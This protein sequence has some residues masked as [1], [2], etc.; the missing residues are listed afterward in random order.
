MLGRLATD[1]R[2]AGIATPGRDGRD[3]LGG[4]LRHDM[5]DR[6]VVEVSNRRSAIAIPVFVPTPSVEATRSGSR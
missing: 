6:E 2:A 1:E 5:T 4:P 3:E